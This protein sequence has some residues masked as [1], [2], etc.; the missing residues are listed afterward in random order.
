M[1][2]FW[3]SAAVMGTL[4]CC[5]LGAVRAENA[6]FT[7][8]GLMDRALASYPTILSKLASK[9]AAQN[10]VSAAG[11]KFWP[12]PSVSTQRSQVDYSGQGSITQPISTLTLSQPIYMGGALMAGQDKATARLSAADFAVLE[13]REDIA[14]RL[15]NAYTEWFRAWSKI[16]ALEENVQLHEQLVGLITR[17]HAQEVASGA[18][19]DL[20]LSRLLQTR[21]DLDAQL[22]QEQ[23]ALT[24]L[25]ELVGEPVSREQ[26]VGQPARWLG[27]PAKADGVAR[28]I[29]NSATLKR[30]QFEAEASS[31]EA[32]EVRAQGLPQ[33]ALQ[34]QRQM[35][36]P[37]V[38][39]ARNFNSFGLVLS[40]APGAGLSTAANTSAA[41]NRAKAAALQVDSA[42][43]ELMGR[44]QADYNDC[45]F[46][47]KRLES[48]QSSVNLARDVSASYD[49]QYLVGRKSWLDLM[50]AVR[51]RAQTLVQ[52]ADV[53]SALL[54]CS[55]RL[56]LYID[57]SAKA[58][59]TAP[60]P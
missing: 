3:R 31:H 8:E 18:D 35:G 11:L 30:Y 26:L 28:A 13:V 48:L 20:G 54:G 43:R 50:N 40:Y 41:L 2:V 52:L 4:L 42:R 17:R 16:Q 47:A 51:E 10:D 56:T 14:Q 19:R 12:S 44:L 27:I 60:R 57:G 7:L 22:S 24:S 59:A 37:Y 36:N 53:Q 1:R 55:R 34:M 46:S 38:V 21:A 5:S 29:D 58:S 32:Q 45:E 9:D 25:S 39:N 33:V 49:R 6:P 23:S 15:I